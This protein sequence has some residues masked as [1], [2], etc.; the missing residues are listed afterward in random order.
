MEL[1]GTILRGTLSAIITLAQ[2]ALLLRAIF[3]WFDMT[4]ESRIAAFLTM[5]T[6]PLIFPI[7]KLFEKFHWFETVP[8][9]M[10]FLTTV[11]LLALLDV[12]VTFL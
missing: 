9:D 3:S 1:F 2:V 6:E 8:F 10:A 7:R 5:L 4:G 11:I 12:L